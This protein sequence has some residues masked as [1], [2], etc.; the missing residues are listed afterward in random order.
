MTTGSIIFTDNFKTDIRSVLAEGRYDNVFILTDDNVHTIYGTAVAAALDIPATHIIT[1]PHGDDNKNLESLT[2]VWQ[3]LC[4]SGA[5]RRSCLVNIGGGMITDLGGFAASTFKRGIHF[6]NVPTTLLAMVDASSG[7]KTGIN[8]NGLK[9]E[10][11][12]FS[13]PRAVIVHAPFLDTCDDANF[14]SGYAEMIKHAL[15]DGNDMWKDILSHDLTRRST[16]PM[17]PMISASVAV[18]Q[19][20]VREDP[21]EQHLRKILNLGHTFGHAFETLSHMRSEGILH[22]YAVAY[23]LVCELFLSTMLLSFPTEKMRQTVRFIRD[24]YGT[25]SFTCNDYETLL[26]LM[27]HDKKNT[28]GHINFALLSDIGT[29]QIDCHATKDDIFE[30]FDFLREAL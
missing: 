19:R 13:Q 3:H 28:A 8:F 18:K 1:I 9:N 20:I 15:I 16:L 2:T 5:T 11:G 25:F 27:R 26:S 6:I 21:C 22:G 30:A 14:L 29:P 12:A 4:S 23:G 10:I 17:L 7:G 24:N